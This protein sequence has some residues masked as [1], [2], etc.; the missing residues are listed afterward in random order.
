MADPTDEQVKDYLKTQ[1]RVY[2]RGLILAAQQPGND[3]CVAELRAIMKRS[4]E[5]APL[6][7]LVSWARALLEIVEE[8]VLT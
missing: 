4:A 1:P 3:A 8:S 6:P 7:D 5:I 2:L